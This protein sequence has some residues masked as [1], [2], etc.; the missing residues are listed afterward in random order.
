MDA[1]VSPALAVVI[2]LQGNFLFKTPL[3][4]K[5]LNNIYSH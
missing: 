1:L 2:A 3:L 5:Y 4:Y